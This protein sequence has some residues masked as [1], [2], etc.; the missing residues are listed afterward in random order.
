M[1][2]LHAVGTRIIVIC[3]NPS[4]DRVIHLLESGVHGV[5]LDDSSPLE[6]ATGVQ[7]VARGGWP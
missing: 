4:L 1:D 6:V 7:G 3:N 5:M 2:S